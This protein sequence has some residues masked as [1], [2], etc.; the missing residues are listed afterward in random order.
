[1]DKSPICSTSLFQEIHFLFFQLVLLNKKERPQGISQF[2]HRI[3]SHE[4]RLIERKLMGFVQTTF[5]VTEQH[6]QQLNLNLQFQDLPHAPHYLR[7]PRL[8]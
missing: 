1:M 4:S 6:H 3:Q 5:E 2:L 7:L 8:L